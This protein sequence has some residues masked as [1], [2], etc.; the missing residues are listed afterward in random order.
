MQQRSEDKL[1]Q[2]HSNR[3]DYTVGPFVRISRGEFVIPHDLGINEEQ[4]AGLKLV[5]IHQ[6]AMGCRS[7]SGHNV[8]VN[9]PSLILSGSQKNYQLCNLFRACQPMKYTMIDISP[10]WLEQHQLKLPESCYHP[11]KAQLLHFSIPASVLAMT[12]QLFACPTH[13]SLHQLYLCAKVTEIT[14]LCLDHF[15]HE[16]SQIAPKLRQRDIDNLQIAKSILM[17]ELESPPSLDELAKRVGMN[18]RK[19]TQGFRQLFG[20]SIYGWLQ[21]YRLETAYQLLSVHDANI[22]TVAY[23]V[24]YT[25]AHFSVAFRKCFGI[26]PNQLKKR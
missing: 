2:A 1:N 14:A 18:T 19:L 12:Q 11:S 16:P 3:E 21:E 22:S 26:S 5:A 23:Q 24:G 13:P 9:S 6:G 20:N 7:S 15:L 8:E 17:Q 25:P 10:E 4:Q